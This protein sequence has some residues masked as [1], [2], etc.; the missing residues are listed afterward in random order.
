MVQSLVT[1]RGRLPGSVPVSL[2]LTLSPAEDCSWNLPPPPRLPTPPASLF[3]HPSPYGSV[4][5]SPLLS[6]DMS[7]SHIPGS[8]WEVHHHL[9]RF[10]KPLQVEISDPTENPFKCQT[11]PSPPRP[12]SPILRVS[13]ITSFHQPSVS[14][15]RVGHTG[16]GVQTQSPRVP[17]M[18]ETT[19]P[20]W[21][22]TEGPRK[23]GPPAPN[24]RLWGKLAKRALGQTPYSPRKSRAVDAGSQ[25]HMSEPG[26]CPALGQNPGS[27][28]TK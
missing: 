12:P 7:P 3:T 18:L 27:Q 5:V 4:L 22:P 15:Q 13:L 17:R 11:V 20:S 1:G 16:P 23:P 14:L 21:K 9:K 8:S 6:P 26:V 25:S 10:S 24:R 19:V 28:E 2:P